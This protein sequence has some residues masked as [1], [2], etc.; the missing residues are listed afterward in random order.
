[1]LAVP[2]VLSNDSIA[3]ELRD[4]HYDVFEVRRPPQAADAERQRTRRRTAVFVQMSTPD[5]ARR[6]IDAGVLVLGFE[7][8]RVE[9]PH[10]PRRRRRA[11]A[12]AASGPLRRGNAPA[13]RSRR[14]QLCCFK[15]LKW[16]SHRA[17]NCPSESYCCWWCKEDH[18]PSDCT[19]KFKVGKGEP[20][21]EGYECPNCSGCHIPWSRRCRRHPEYAQAPQQQQPQP[22]QERVQPP[23][24]IMR[25]A[26]SSSASAWHQ[27]IAPEASPESPVQRDDATPDDATPDDA[28]PSHATHSDATPSDATP[29][30]ATPSRGAPVSTAQIV[31][32]I[33]S[34][35]MS[36]ME[37]SGLHEAVDM[38]HEL[39][40]NI[41]GFDEKVF[42]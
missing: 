3:A 4:G 24:Q 18:S 23:A 26:G 25:P 6:A 33:F 37:E 38:I 41:P 39:T 32:S 27:H 11:A 21:V 35:V 7:R 9:R 15:C 22:E 8:F 2:A 36:S 1:M 12:S 14:A 40:S 31:T 42:F 13:P 16:G 34:A 10:D 5:E 20:M 29:D 28:T 17:A 19:S 30:D